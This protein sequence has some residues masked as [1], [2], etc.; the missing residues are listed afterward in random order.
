MAIDK[1][2][3]GDVYSIAVLEYCNVLMGRDLIADCPNL[4]KVYDRVMEAD[5][6]KKYLAAR[7]EDKIPSFG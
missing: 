6:I 5:G 4:K 7:P 1:I 2:T 3:W